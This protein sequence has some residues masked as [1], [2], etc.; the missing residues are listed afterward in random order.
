[1]P[2]SRRQ[3]LTGMLLIALALIIG[4]CSHSP[5][6]DM[7]GPVA[8]FI[9]TYFDD[10]SIAE[11]VA[12]DGGGFVVTIK[13]GAQIVFDASNAWADINGRGETLPAMLIT[14]QLPERV[15]EYLTSMELVTG[16]YRLNRSW[17]NLRVELADSYFTYDDQTGDLTYPEVA[18]KA[19]GLYAHFA[20][21]SDIVL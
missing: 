18:G 14:D 7:P 17:H 11:A 5:Y 10:G 12:T 19:A 1:M 4:G 21:C 8:S 2:H 3:T 20:P 16:V 13:N 6:D 15:V 9:D